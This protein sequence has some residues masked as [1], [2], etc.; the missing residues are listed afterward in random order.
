MTAQAAIPRSRTV[1][2]ALSS[3][4]QSFNATMEMLISPRM[5]LERISRGG[6]RLSVPWLV[7]ALCEMTWLYAHYSPGR[8]PVQLMLT[9]TLQLIIVAFQYLVVTLPLAGLIGLMGGRFRISG[10][11]A[12]IFLAGFVIRFGTLTAALAGQAFFDI[13]ADPAGQSLT[14]LA[15]LVSETDQ[16]PLHHVLV[17]LDL[18]RLYGVALAAWGTTVV[19]R[20]IP[21]TRA[22]LITVGFW[23]SWLAIST[24]IKW[25]VS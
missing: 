18:V 4:A 6:V 7:S 25:Y 5:C 12:V 11:L 15:W 21:R 17:Q 2:S 24:F 14:N 8:K 19:V 10:L 9:L 22:V 16:R 23:C 13:D 20:N 1:Q 3:I